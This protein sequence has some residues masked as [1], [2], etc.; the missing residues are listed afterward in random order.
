MTKDLY[1]EEIALEEEA[2][3]ITVS[4]FHKEHL[5]RTLEETFSETFL[6]SHIIKH[7]LNP[8]INRINSWL[9]EAN[10]GRA[11][12]KNLAAKLLE[13]IDTPTVAFLMLKAIFNKV[14]VYHQGKPCTFTSL[15]I[16]GGDLIHDEMRL[17]EF[18][19][20]YRS[21]SRKVHQDFNKRD[22]PRYKREEYMQKVFAK[23]EM[24]WS[25]WSSSDKLHVG[26]ALL[27]AFKDATGDL[28]V[29]LSGHGK[30]QRLIVQ[31]SEGLLEAIAKNAEACE[32]LFTTYFPM[33]VP[34]V[35]WD[36]NRLNIG[37]Y[38]SHNVASYPLVKGSR[39]TYRANLE[40]LAETGQLD[41]IFTAVNAIQQTRWKINQPVLEAMEYVYSKN[42][43][44]GGLPPADPLVPDDPPLELEGLAPDHPLVKEYRAYCFNIH[45]F[46]RRIVG[47][48][49]M[50][51]RAFQIARK[52]S[53]YDVIYFPHDMD[54]RGRIYPKPSGLNPQGPDYVKGLLQFAEG[55]ALGRS[56]V[57][58]LAIHGA[59][60]WGEDKLPLHERENWGHSNLQF[61]RSVAA[62]PRNNLEWTRADQPCQ[63]LAW[64][65]EWAR[66][67]EE[68]QP[69]RFVSY[70]HVDL[71][72][73]CSGLQHFSAMLRDEVGGYHVNMVPNDERQDVYGAVAK[74]AE[75]LIREDLG[76][77]KDALARAWLNFGMSRKITKR[78]VM[79]KP[80]SGT[81]TSCGTYVAEA[82]EELIADGVPLP[83]DK[84]DMWTF[85]AYGADK[86]WQAIPH[87]VVAA[88]GAM[89]WLMTVSRL[90]AKSQPD[91][92]RLEWTTPM[93][94]PVHQSKFDVKTR[95]V[96]TWFDGRIIQPR[97]ANDTDKL[98]P[99]QM[100]SSV[101]P[102]FI[103]S[104]DAAHLQSTI[105]RAA[106]AGLTDFAVVHDS[107]G[108]HACDVDKFSRIIREAFVDL[109][110]NHDVLGAFL[111]ENY[112]N[113]KEEYREE[114]PDMPP[115][116]T[117]SLLGVL[118]NQ[119]FFS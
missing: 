94:L 111:A 54:S 82:V 89:K 106:E 80:Y 74:V 77:E 66:A 109:Y 22:L 48:R 112:E 105:S 53:K 62:D 35:N 2:R 55:K 44:C 78:P 10:T 115:Q 29:V 17:R 81:R 18:D 40:K 90:V 25:S 19:D 37:S 64:C 102:S 99:R 3:G 24:E 73:T 85:K 104:L 87:V 31:A 76:T 98:D 100:A 14:G 56:G 91:S 27:N 21:W 9:A 51:G 36:A 8:F 114:I 20:L 26:S 92:R 39:K 68:A 75:D 4:R 117:L 60:C 59:N 45:E 23:A 1:L 97:I 32:A 50:A 67:H 33:V 43:A 110:Q 38:L 118:D 7:Y 84:K 49:V 46:N 70:L 83:W 101:P 12:R 108:V 15:A 116:G 30:G 57:R 63:F 79:V 96:N 6:G 28:E 65:F 113:I 119:F 86:V 16:Y 42:I 58:W 71:D 107:F 88:D 11:G 103:H 5:K 13:P 95:T 93:G 52:M 72:A 61:A 69:E 41:R 34:P 47:K